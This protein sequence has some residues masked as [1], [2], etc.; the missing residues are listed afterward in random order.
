MKILVH[1]C[2]GPCLIFPHEQ[3]K[4]KGHA[5][6]AFYYN[7]N[8]HP[9]GEYKSRLASFIKYCE[10]E[11]VTAIEAGYDANDYF[12]KIDADTPDRCRLCYRIR[13]MKTAKVAAASGYDSFTTTLLVSPYQKHDDLRAA[14]EEAALASGVPFFYEDFRPGFRAGRTK[15]REMGLYSQKYCGC[16]FSEEE[17][18]RRSS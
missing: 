4:E 15:A 17:R 6:T 12:D 14:G 7:P 16:R 18:N 5:V 3:L 1:A 11:G 13:L 9:A 10:V 8:I 2:C